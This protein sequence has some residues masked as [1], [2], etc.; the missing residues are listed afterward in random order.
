M[1]RWQEEWKS[2]SGVQRKR[3]TDQLWEAAGGLCHL[4]HHP[5]RRDEASVDHLTP[6][7]AGGHTTWDNL[8][9]AHR[10]CN[11]S[12]GNRSLSRSVP[13]VDHLTAIMDRGRVNARE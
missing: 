2:L 10:R 3:I 4:C 1:S 7:S 11:Y 12:R 8:A 9:L 6:A 5:V 13:T